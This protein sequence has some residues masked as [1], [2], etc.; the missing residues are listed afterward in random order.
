MSEV[1]PIET[2]YNGYRFRSRLEARWAVFFDSLRVKYEYEPQGFL[3][4]SG[5][6]YLPD[7]K[8]R[9]YGTRGGNC[10]SWVHPCENC[11]HQISDWYDFS[12]WG[13]GFCEYC[14]AKEM[15]LLTLRRPP[16]RTEIIKCDKQEELYTPFDL[17]IEVKGFMTKE[18]AA[19]IR[20]FAECGNAV[21]VVSAIP[22]RGCS[23]DSDIGSYDHMNG[24][25]IYPF[26]YEL[27][28]GDY[29]AAYPAAD[30]SGHFYLWGDDS[31]YIVTED[32]NRV[33]K[34]YDNARQARFE[35][36]EMP[37]I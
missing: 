11:K 15:P 18:D 37:R 8:V 23:S 5:K 16:E 9:C 28:D 25:D 26:N 13:K 2:V 24:T 7:F 6:R 20:E 14:T 34:A 1:R 22:Q 32:I 33:E 30:S 10:S 3:L 12:S 4:P 36:G 17:Y 29:F 27:I 35:H 31:N 21:L 19:K